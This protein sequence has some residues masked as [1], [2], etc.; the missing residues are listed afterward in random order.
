MSLL[1]ILSPKSLRKV[2]CSVRNFRLMKDNYIVSSVLNTQ[3]MEDYV[4]VNTNA[5]LR[6]WLFQCITVLGF[7]YCYYLGLFRLMWIM[8]V[9]KISV[10]ILIIYAATTAFIGSMTLKA[11]KDFKASIPFLETYSPVCW[12]IAG[13]LQDLGLIGTVIGF[14]IMLGPTFAGINLSDNIATQKMIS[15]MSVGMS[16]ALITTLVGLVCAV[17]LRFQLLNLDTI[18]NAE[19]KD[20]DTF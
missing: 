19:E 20:N 16:T 12:Q 13:K 6:W 9:S 14:M 17:L 10:G 8:D 5:S 15:T 1:V 2:G 11:E 18:T 4:M 3:V 7:L